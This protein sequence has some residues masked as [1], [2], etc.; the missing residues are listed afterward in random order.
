MLQ[1]SVKCNS[2]TKYSWC[3]G[4]IQLA[5]LFTKCEASGIEI[6]NVLQKEKMPV[7]FV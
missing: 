4:K 7:E 2:T 1:Q 3:P 5:N 6:L